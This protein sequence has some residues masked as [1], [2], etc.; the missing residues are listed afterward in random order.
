MTKALTVSQL[1]V[2]ERERE[3]LKGIRSQPLAVQRSLEVVVEAAVRVRHGHRGR[4][5]GPP[6]REQRRGEEA[7]P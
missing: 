4:V 1:Q 2:I 5:V 3:L 6:R 7:Q